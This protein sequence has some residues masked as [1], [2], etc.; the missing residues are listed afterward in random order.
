VTVTYDRSG[1]GILTSSYRI[2]PHADPKVI[3]LRYNAPV[4]VNADGTLSVHYA[5]GCMT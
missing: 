5:T 2:A 4:K 1:G 3:R